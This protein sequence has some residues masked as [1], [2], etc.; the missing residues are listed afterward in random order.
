M[1]DLE[2][3]KT[4]IIERRVDEIMS[5]L[6]NC[7]TCYPYTKEATDARAKY[8]GS[9]RKKVIA[10]LATDLPGIFTEEAKNV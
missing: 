9:L 4:Y 3:L 5:H 1:S 8:R 7:E 2:I 6:C 10:D